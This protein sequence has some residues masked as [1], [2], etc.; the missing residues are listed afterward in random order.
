MNIELGI[1]KD[2]RVMLACDAPLPDVVRRVEYYREQR[3]FM[4]VYNDFE[5]HGDKLMECEIP[6]HLAL[7][8]E[9]SPNIVV[10]T[11]FKDEEPLGYKVPLVK[12]GDL[13]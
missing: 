3:L 9:K 5:K 1:L 6:D 13:Y 7:P 8:V 4:L 12:V 2:G 10:F 11:L